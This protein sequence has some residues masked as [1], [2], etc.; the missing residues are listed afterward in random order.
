MDK[1]TFFYKERYSYILNSLNYLYGDEIEIK[2]LN[3]EEKPNGKFFYVVEFERPITDHIYTYDFINECRGIIEN[4]GEI[5]LDYALEADT[6]IRPCHVYLLE[7]IKEAGLPLDK[8][9]WASNNSFIMDPHTVDIRG[10]KLKT[11]YFPHLLVEAHREQSSYYKPTGKEY[12]D[13]SSVV[14]FLMLNRRVGINKFYSIHELVKRGWHKR[15]HMSFISMR[16]NLAGMIDEHKEWSASLAELGLTNPITQPLQLPDDVG[17]PDKL[18]DTNEFLYTVN[19]NWYEQAKVNLVVETWHDYTIPGWDAFD[20]MVHHTE[21]IFK[22]IGFNC[23]FVVF[24][25]PEYLDRLHKLGFR[26]DF[27]SD[28]DSEYDLEPDQSKRISKAL[29]L[30]NKYAHNYDSERMKEVCLHNQNLFLD[31]NFHKSIVQKYFLNHIAP[32]KSLI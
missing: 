9:L 13:S 31:L 8:F 27:L 1:L 12:N 32:L 3:W 10:Y 19:P 18:V 17:S 29:D 24:S 4:G 28:N 6:A 21:K 23:P 16:S 25:G 20:N 22:S 7:N 2:K 14:D 26:T 11:L 15:S 5:I 30:A